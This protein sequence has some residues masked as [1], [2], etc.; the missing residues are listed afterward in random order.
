[1]FFTCNGYNGFTF[2]SSHISTGSRVL[3]PPSSFQKTSPEKPALEKGPK[4]QGAQGPSQD[5][6]E[7]GPETQ[8]VQER[9][10][11]SS[12][13]REKTAGQSYDKEQTKSDASASDEDPWRS[14]ALVSRRVEELQKQNEELKR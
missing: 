13:D 5:D 10:Q 6:R 14:L 11:G 4:T 9:A 12:N 8:R 1:M 3:L 7:K 2:K